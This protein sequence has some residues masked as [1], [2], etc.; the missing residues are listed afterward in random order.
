MKIVKI[1]RVGNSNVITLPREF[2]ALG[3]TAGES[4]AID[5]L[6]DGELQIMTQAQLRAHIRDIGRR[7]IAEDRE[8]LELL[9][10]YDRGEEV[11][12]KTPDSLKS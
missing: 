11:A 3:F 12:R 9:A 6:A 1:R 7:V 8:A 5:Q 4:V 2:E 10:A